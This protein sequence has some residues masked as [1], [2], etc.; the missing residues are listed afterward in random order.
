M[1]TQLN[2]GDDPAPGGSNGAGS[3]AAHELKVRIERRQRAAARHPPGG[4][5]PDEQAAEGHDECRYTKKRDDE[6]LKRAKH[7]AEQQAGG[8]HDDPGQRVVVTEAELQGQ[9]LGLQRAHDH[10]Q[11]AEERAN[12][13]V[14][15]A[16]D[17]DQHHA[18]CHD[19]NRRRLDGKVPQIARGQEHS[20]GH[21]LEPEPDNRKGHDHAKHAG[22]D[23]RRLHERT[24]QSDPTIRQTAQRSTIRRA[25]GLSHGRPSPEVF[26][27]RTNNPAPRTRRGAGR[28]GWV[29]A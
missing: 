15:V 12:R 19:G 9:N 23:F 2:C 16:G 28:F 17:D 8:E 1:P 6:A 3:T 10:G 20:A 11:E 18:G 5:A 13:E 7:G 21:D 24:N 22:V 4:A 27:F 26:V 14:D 29:D 25:G